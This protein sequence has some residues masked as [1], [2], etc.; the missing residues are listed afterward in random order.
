M[1]FLS[2]LV[3]FCWISFV[4]AKDCAVYGISDSPQGL[5][6]SF[7]KQDLSLWCDTTSGTYFLDTVPVVAAF[8]Y[9]VEEGAVPL[10]FKTLDRELTIIKLKNG[11]FSAE[12]VSDSSSIIGNCQ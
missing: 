10:V 2:L 7:K 12:L 5:S 8:H 3:A 11:K 6:C 9:E 1:K 4:Y